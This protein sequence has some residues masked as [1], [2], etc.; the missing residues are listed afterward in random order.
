MKKIIFL[1]LFLIFNVVLFAQEQTITLETAGG[2]IKGTL[3]LPDSVKKV[4]VALIISGSGPTDRDGNQS[5]MKNNSLKYLAE[6]L[7]KQGIASVRF[8][9]RAIGESAGAATSEASLRFETY[10][11]DVKD[12]I[13]MLSEDKRFTRIIVIGHSEGSLIGMVA[14]SGNPKVSAFVSIAGT[15]LPAD[16]LLKVQLASQPQGIRDIIF[17][18]LDSLKHGDTLHNVTVMLYSLFRPSVQP[19]MISWFRYNPQEW[20]TRLNIPILILQGDKDIQISVDDAQNLSKAAPGAVL[21]IIPNM[22]HVLKECNTLDRQD[23]ITIYNNPDL[24]VKKD[25]VEVIAG[26]ITN[27]K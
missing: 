27:L 7:G 8:D 20:I 6:E 24:P 2:D 12:W 14:S 4:P 21:K 26:F 13:R 9:K 23:Q 5:S 25:L 15:S 19:Y 10:I 1:Q 11:N 16:E 22:N 3:L 17:P 18:K